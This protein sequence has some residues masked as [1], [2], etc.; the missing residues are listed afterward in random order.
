MRIVVDI[1]IDGYQGFR[2]PRVATDSL[3][4]YEWFVTV[5]K[6]MLNKYRSGSKNMM[7]KVASWK[8]DGSL[9]FSSCSSSAASVS[10]R[11][12]TCRRQI[13][14][15]TCPASAGF[16]E[17]STEWRGAAA[18]KDELHQSPGASREAK[19]DRSHLPRCTST[20]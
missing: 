12:F 6:E 5:L 11:S 18:R 9:R 20:V 17:T 10:S 7:W 1:G 19:A 3:R 16:R 14:Q 8:S 13:C 15:A 4:L 2:R